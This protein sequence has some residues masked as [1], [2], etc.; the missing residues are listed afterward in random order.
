MLYKNA[1]ID[2][3]RNY[4]NELYIIKS[5][6]L[7]Q[8]VLEDL[9]FGISFFIEGNFLT[10]EAYGELPFSARVINS[11]GIAGRKFHFV[12]LNE[13]QFQLFPNGDDESQ[14]HERTTFS[15]GDTIVYQGLQLVFLRDERRKQMVDKPFI[16]LYQS[17]ASITGGYVGKL[18]VAWAEEGAGVINLSINGPNSIKDLDFINGL[19][20]RYQ[21]YDLDKKNETA[22]RTI[23]FIDQQLVDI[24]DSLQRVEIII[25][26]FRGKNTVVDASEETTRLFEKLEGLD[27]Q[28]TDFLV[29]KNYYEYLTSYLKQSDNRD[30]VIAPSSVGITDPV[31]SAL[32]AKMI[33]I[34]VDL[35]LIAGSE[36]LKNP[37]VVERINRL[38]EIKKNVLEAVNNIQATESIRQNYLLKQIAATEGQMRDLPES[39]RRYISIKR[40]YSLL[41]NL[42]VFFTPEK[43]RSKHIQSFQHD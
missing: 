18:S 40:K 30:V 31:L 1:L 33:D 7:I 20:R 32:I 5:Y 42:Y 8:R 19:I 25:E 26:K 24:S 13:K 34:Q 9:N 27:V 29:H 17:P 11:S 36:K 6:P 41:E 10:T 38:A 39:E 22:S 37:L 15:F 2:P 3:Y 43:I 28:N 21:Q 12:I 23:E 14:T 35:K 16:F 4:L